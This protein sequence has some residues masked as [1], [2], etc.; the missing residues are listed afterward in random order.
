M[1]HAAGWPDPVSYAQARLSRA[2]WLDPPSLGCWCSSACGLTSLGSS[3]LNRLVQS[4]PPSTHASVSPICSMSLVS[5]SALSERHARPSFIHCS[6]AARVLTLVCWSL[7]SIADLSL[8][9]LA[10][11]VRMHAFNALLSHSI[12]LVLLLLQPEAAA[13][14]TPS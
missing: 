2:S 9:C 4:M 11:N 7:R 14:P 1:P 13:L 12:S 8:L 5:V 3:P 6:V 10:S